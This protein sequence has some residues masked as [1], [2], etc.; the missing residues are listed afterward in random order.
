MQLRLWWSV[1]RPPAQDYSIGIYLVEPG[2]TV[3]VSSDGA[4]TVSDAP[5]ETNRW[6]PGRY[7]LDERELTLPTP[8]VSGTYPLY[9]A[10][11]DALQNARVGAPGTNQDKLMIVDYV[12]VKAW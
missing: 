9:M 3:R 7:Y 11:Y 2:P 12:Y 10:V 4:P 6:T 8:M 1:D 5:R